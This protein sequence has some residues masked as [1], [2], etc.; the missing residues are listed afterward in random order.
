MFEHFLVSNFALGLRNVCTLAKFKFESSLQHA[1]AVIAQSLLIAFPRMQTDIYAHFTVN[2]F[3][4]VIYVICTIYIYL[5]SIQ[6]MVHWHRIHLLTRFLTSLMYARPSPGSIL[7]RRILNVLMASQ[8]VSK[9]S[10]L[11]A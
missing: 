9:W 10:L 7:A 5:I 11:V 8:G 2:A 4:W 1:C 6:Y 3:F